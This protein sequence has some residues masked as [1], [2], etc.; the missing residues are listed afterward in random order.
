M[1]YRIYPPQDI[2]QATVDLPLS[3]SVSNR[4]IMIGA[5][6]SPQVVPQ[7][8]ADC[9]DTRVM[10]AAVNSSDETV[11]VADAGT[12]MRF[13][14]AWFAC[15]PG[16]T[17]RLVGT[18]R[19]CNR[20]IG[21][22]VEA[23]RQCGAQI[24]YLGN[25]GF[26]PLLIHGQQLTG[27]DIRIDATISSQFISALLMIAPLMADGVRLTLDG[28][29]ASLP[30][31]DLTLSMMNRAGA[32]AERTVDLIEVAPG[33]YRDA[34]A[35]KAEKDWSA[36]AFWYEIEAL[37]C[38]FLTL[39]G[40]DLGSRQP[41][42]RAVDIFAD[43][44]VATSEGED[45]LEDVDL[46]GSPDSS[47]RLT[48]D[49][50]ATPDLA[51]AVIVTCAMNGVPFNI[52]G[53]HSLKIKE[54]DRMAALADELLKIGVVTEIVGDHTMIWDGRRRPVLEIPQFETYND[55][56]MAMALAPVCAYIPGIVIKDA[57]V[58][59]KSYPSFWDDLRS[60]GFTVVDA[61]APEQSQENLE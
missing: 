47:P 49:L 48:V 17:V 2:L 45:S 31:I 27:G 54:C 22:L 12:A 13:L 7:P 23:L 44:G 30:Y 18:E 29:A 25:E 55:H 53:L 21:P 19:M 32:S 15:R 4:A 24:D 34:E 20:P 56:R 59:G 3:K 40:L 11:D 16:R 10:L 8:L 39:T 50:A 1:N 14:T 42:R 6:A 57:G 37:T 33:G 43:L 58:V 52:S 26:P 38:G 28:D 9:S 51:P 46:A 61:D 60:A 35:L 41:D 5:L 36:A